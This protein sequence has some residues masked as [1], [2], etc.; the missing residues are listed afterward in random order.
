M[1]RFK[2]KDYLDAK[3]ISAYKLGQ[4]V[5]GLE[6]VTVRKYA[7]GER[8]PTLDS[9]DRLIVALRELTS[10]RVSVCDLLEYVED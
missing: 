4:T 8:M 6:P 9:L 10:E 5:K 3:G 1:I 2:L 7:A